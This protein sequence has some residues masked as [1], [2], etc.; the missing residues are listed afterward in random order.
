MLYEVITMQS[1]DPLQFKTMDDF[2]A[3]FVKQ[4]N[5]FVEIKLRGNDIRNNFV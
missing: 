1:G 3:A 5:H 2:R 4:L